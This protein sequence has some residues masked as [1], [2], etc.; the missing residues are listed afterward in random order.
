MSSRRFLWC[1]I[2]A[3]ELVTAICGVAIQFKRCVPPL[4]AILDQTLCLAVP[5]KGIR[6]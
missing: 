5:K 2:T 3:V 6:V 1:E 4:T